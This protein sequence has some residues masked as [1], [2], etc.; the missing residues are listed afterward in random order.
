MH[1]AKLKTQWLYICGARYSA[2]PFP[3]LGALMHACIE[4]LRGGLLIRRLA[5]LVAACLAHPPVAQLLLLILSFSEALLP[6]YPGAHCVLHLS[7]PAL[8]FQALHAALKSGFVPSQCLGFLCVP[9]AKLCSFSL[10]H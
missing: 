6:M 8:T 7:V 1:Q 9:C 4:A 10:P 5:R 2:A 3:G